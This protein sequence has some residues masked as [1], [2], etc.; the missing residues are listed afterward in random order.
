MVDLYKPQPTEALLTYLDEFQTTFDQRYVQ[1]ALRLL[2]QAVME[3]EVGALT[4]ADRHERREERRNYRNGYRRTVWSTSCGDLALDVPKLRK[5]SYYPNFMQSSDDLESILHGL[6]RESYV[7]GVDAERVK[8]ALR[9]L[10]L[11]PIPA[12]KLASICESLNDAVDEFRHGRIDGRFVEL[13]LDLRDV[14]MVRRGQQRDRR[15]AV[16]VG[17][18]ENRASRLLAHEIVPAVDER[19]W[20]EFIGNLE[21]RGLRRVEQV[22]GPVDYRLRVAVQTA[23]SDAAWQPVRAFSSAQPQ[24]PDFPNLFEVW[25]GASPL[26]ALDYG[27]GLCLPVGIAA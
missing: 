15:L 16:A 10:I 21:R 18:D 3:L 5:G 7:E 25:N 26:E 23:L 8:E 17:V 19:F 14:S 27:P 12:E 1:K 9:L 4:G 22:T 6:I 2:I 24:A 13:H 11:A 20:E